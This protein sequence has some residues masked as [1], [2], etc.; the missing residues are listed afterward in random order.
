MLQIKSYRQDKVLR[1]DA[2]TDVHPSTLPH[3]FVMSLQSISYLKHF[4]SH[5]TENSIA[6]LSYIFI[7][8]FIF[9][10]VNNPLLTSER[11]FVSFMTT[12]HVVLR[13][14]VMHVY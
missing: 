12:R 2:Q 6:A 10:V 1:T 3:P 4:I 9:E 11:G 14:N 8:T 7:Y 13:V 5:E